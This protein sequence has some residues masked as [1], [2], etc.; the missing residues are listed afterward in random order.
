MHD[1]ILKAN[2]GIVIEI[3]IKYLNNQIVWEH[4]LELWIYIIYTFLVYILDLIVYDL[5]NQDSWCLGWF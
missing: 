5:V 1:K 3:R 4:V 2:N